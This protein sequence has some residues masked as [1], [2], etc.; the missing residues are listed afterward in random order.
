VAQQIS[1]GIVYFEY[2]KFDIQN[3][4]RDMLR[5]KSELMKSNAKIRVR[6][7]GH[8][9][10]RGTEEYNMA[11][12]ERRARAAYNYL[13]RLGVKP[14]QME[15][16]SLGKRRPAVQGENEA[17]WAKNRRAEFVVIAGQ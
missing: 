16:L 7:E 12:G 10:E 2:D 4:Y 6:V 9:D 8:C 3:E 17:A 13:T 15:L 14:S 5:Q 1:G 11:L